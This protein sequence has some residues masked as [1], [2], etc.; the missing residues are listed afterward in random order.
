[1]RRVALP[2]RPRP[3]LDGRGRGF[4]WRSKSPLNYKF[5]QEFMSPPFLIGLAPYCFAGWVFRL[6]PRLR[7]SAG[8]AAV[9]PL[10]DDALQ[11]FSTTVTPVRCS[12]YDWD[13]LKQPHPCYSCTGIRGTT[14][15]STRKIALAFMAV[16]GL[17]IFVPGHADSAGKID[18]RRLNHLDKRHGFVRATAADFHA[19][20]RD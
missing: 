2:K 8:V 7:R 6:E 11:T 20:D 17:A 19:E 14:M 18:Y 5:P 4:R 16:L 1:M 3:R 9:D 13:A 15:L 10:R 12:A